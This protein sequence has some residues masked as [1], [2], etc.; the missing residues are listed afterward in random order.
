MPFLHAASLQT[1]ALP[2]SFNPETSIGKKVCKKHLANSGPVQH[3]LFCHRS[4]TGSVS[5]LWSSQELI[6]LFC[7]G[8]L[9]TY[10]ASPL[11]CR[12][13]SNGTNTIEEKK[14]Q[15]PNMVSLFIHKVLPESKSSS[16]DKTKPPHPQYTNTFSM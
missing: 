11:Y 6:H 9:D 10:S 4:T 13:F 5:T 1:W 12:S 8:L 15:N 3:L 2:L 16:G 7:L 14:N